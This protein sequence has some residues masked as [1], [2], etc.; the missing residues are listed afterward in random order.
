LKKERGAKKKAGR[1]ISG[2][3]NRKTK[4]NPMLEKEKGREPQ[5]E[6]VLQRKQSCGFLEEKSK[7]I[8]KRCEGEAGLGKKK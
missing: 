3:P 5:R 6:G 4:Q 1:K 7:K 2:G 8:S